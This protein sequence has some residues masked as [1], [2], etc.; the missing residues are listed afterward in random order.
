MKRLQ[1]NWKVGGSTSPNPRAAGVRGRINTRDVLLICARSGA[2]LSKFQGLVME[3]E[4]VSLEGSEHAVDQLSVRDR[5]LHT[6]AVDVAFSWNIKINDRSTLSRLSAQIP[7]SPLFV[8]AC[9]TMAGKITL[10]SS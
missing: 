3:D 6:I 5:G 9:N 7:R 1:G 10:L 8:I 2:Q 4:F